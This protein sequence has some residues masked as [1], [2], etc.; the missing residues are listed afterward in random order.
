MMGLLYGL[1]VAIGI[2]AALVFVANRPEPSLNI[3]SQLDIQ[4]GTMR[5]M[6]RWASLVIVIIIFC[7]L[8]GSCLASVA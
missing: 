4:R 2:I 1:L 8:T 6:V 7:M 5:R 3:T